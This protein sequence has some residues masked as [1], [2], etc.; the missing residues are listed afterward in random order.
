MDRHQCYL[1]TVRVIHVLVGEQRGFCEKIANLEMLVTTF[2]LAL[3]EVA[4]R[5]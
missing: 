3:L 4:H 1:F 2:L 5:V